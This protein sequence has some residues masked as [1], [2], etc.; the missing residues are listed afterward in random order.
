MNNRQ[1]YWRAFFI[2]LAV[3]MVVYAFYWFFGVDRSGGE[4]AFQRGVFAVYLP[5]L[6]MVIAVQEAM[7]IHSWGG[8]GFIILF[9]PLIGVFAYSFVV[10]FIVLL[11]RKVTAHH[12]KFA[13]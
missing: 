8:L 3:Q 2:A 10:A 4:T 5:I 7:D 1:A 6:L 13:A 11:F 12:D 9:A